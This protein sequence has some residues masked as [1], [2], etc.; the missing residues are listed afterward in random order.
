MSIS[1]KMIEEKEFK[2]KPR[3]YDP[4]EVDDFLDEVVGGE[5][6]AHKQR[7]AVR[8]EQME[9]RENETNAL[10]AQLAH[11]QQARPVAAPVVQNESASASVLLRNAQLVYDQTVRDAQEQA[12][13]VVGKAHEEAQL[14]VENARDEMKSLTDQLDTM[15]SAAA[16][17]R[18]RFLRLVEDQKHVLTSESEL[19]KKA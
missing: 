8:Q 5:R 10:K 1:L 11:A 17:Y 14:I 16:D 9:A 13:Q 18:A 3:G 6:L 4:D 15:R 12:N 7:R 2:F 19:F